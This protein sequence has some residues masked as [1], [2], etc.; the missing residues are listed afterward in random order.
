MEEKDNKI[1]EVEFL[2]IGSVT[3]QVDIGLRRML[4]SA[5]CLRK[6]PRN[7]KTEAIYSAA[8]DVVLYYFSEKTILF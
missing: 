7:C 8:K 1:I 4:S 6:H 2:L 3:L 5:R